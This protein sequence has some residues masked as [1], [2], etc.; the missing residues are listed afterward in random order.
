[1]PPG[2]IL[3]VEKTAI[4]VGKE[5][6][7]RER[8]II[9]SPFQRVRVLQHIRGNEWK[10]QVEPNPGLTDYVESGQIIILW[11]D[12]KS[13]L[14]ETNSIRLAEINKRDGFEPDPPV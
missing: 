1:V 10:A 2:M 4:I 14:K 12:H 3:A 5:Y 8:R 13:F 9:G 11:Q 6:A 7:F